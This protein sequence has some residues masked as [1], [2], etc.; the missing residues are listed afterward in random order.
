MRAMGIGLLFC[1]VGIFGQ[2]LTEWVY[3]QTPVL[4]TFQILMGALASVAYAR[5][6]GTPDE[7]P[8]GV[9]GESV[10]EPVTVEEQLL[11]GEGA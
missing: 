11:V 9:I 6:H 3:R 7:T 10:P 8:M 2:S 1:V 4:F 5:T